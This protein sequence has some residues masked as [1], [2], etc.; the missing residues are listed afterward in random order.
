LVSDPKALQWILSTSA[1]WYEKQRDRRYMSR[2]ASGKGLGWA[3]GTFTM[4]FSSMDRNDVVP[5]EDHKRQKRILLP[6][7]GG[8]EAEASL[9]V[10]RGCAESVSSVASW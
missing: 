1:Q 3:Q 2:L 8:P 6:G 9:P 5:G 7:L 10:F 4:R